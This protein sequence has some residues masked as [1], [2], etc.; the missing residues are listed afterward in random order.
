ME[1]QTHLHIYIFSV[2][3]YKKGVKIKYVCSNRIYFSF[4]MCMYYNFIVHLHCIIKCH[5]NSH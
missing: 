4:F 2:I 1:T 5:M 3:N